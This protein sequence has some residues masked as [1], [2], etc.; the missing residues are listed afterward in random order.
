[1][2]DKTD[3]IIHATAI[4]HAGA[5]CLISGPSGS[6]KSALALQLM[7]LGAGLIAD[8]RVCL[9]LDGTDLIASCPPT[10]LGLIEARGV[11]IL[12]ATPASPAPVKLAVDMGKLEV[13][14]M[15]PPRN[16]MHLGQKVPLL[17]HVDKPHFPATVLQMLS[18]GRSS[19]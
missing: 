5:V 9:T 1:M 15:P 18:H 13:A 19:R 7:A 16:V 3:H 6:G 11:G 8:D 10:I 14:R 17:W 2:P 4:V 12:N